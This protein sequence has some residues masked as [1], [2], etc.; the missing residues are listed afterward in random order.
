MRNHVG[1]F[2]TIRVQGKVLKGFKYQD[3]I[4]ILRNHQHVNQE[5]QSSNIIT[6]YFIMAFNYHEKT[7][8]LLAIHT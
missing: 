2:L 5:D 8:E 3:E 4:S 6:L 7:F 1:K